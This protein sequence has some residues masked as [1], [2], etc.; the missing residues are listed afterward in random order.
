[1][2]VWR[3]A[4]ALLT[5]VVWVLLG[6][7]A[8]M[9]PKLEAPRLI[10]TRIQL[11]PTGNMSQQQV[12]L[13]VHALNPNDRSIA[14]RSIDAQLE[15]E[16]LPFAQGST[17]AA[18]TLPPRGEVD[19]DLDVVANMN[20]AMVVVANRLGHHSVDYRIYGTVHLK[21][22]LLHKLAFDQKGRAKW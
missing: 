4:V 7:C 3:S 19:F 14:I 8:S 21:G 10:V 16:N 6:G 22:S 11:G 15:V 18:F 13:T 2:R 1:M 9:A 17:V 5:C 20:T 12:Q